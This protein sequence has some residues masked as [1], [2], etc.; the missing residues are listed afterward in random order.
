M[1]PRSN[2][3]KNNLK[4]E[5]QSW[6]LPRTLL[7][8]KT[9]IHPLKKDAIKQKPNDLFRSSDWTSSMDRVFDNFRHEFEKSL[10]SFPTTSISKISTLLCDI[11]DEGNKYIIK[12]EMPGIKKDEIKLKISD[13]SLEVSGQHKEEEQEKKKNYIRK[14]RSEI[15]YYRVVPLPD[16][17]ISDKTQAK[18]IDGVLTIMAPK[19]TP[20]K[21]K[22]SSV[23]VQ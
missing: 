9:Y 14:E 18:L 21:P 3:E 10:L 11:T 22:S 12:A 16:K 15:S 8:R 23:Q 4:F 19:V 1:A 2:L 17:I 13:N 5:N 6:E 7:I 20:T